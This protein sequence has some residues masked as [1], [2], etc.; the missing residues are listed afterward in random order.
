MA[1]LGSHDD[2][3][4]ERLLLKAAFFEPDPDS[5]DDT[6]GPAHLRD[7][8]PAAHSVTDYCDDQRIPYRGPK[9]GLEETGFRHHR[10]RA[11]QKAGDISQVTAPSDTVPFPSACPP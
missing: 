4:S 5:V 11:V 9:H 10:A 1:A 3:D 6:L 2:I 8:P 7:G